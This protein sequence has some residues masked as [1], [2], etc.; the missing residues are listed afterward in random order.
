LAFAQAAMRMGDEAGKAGMRLLEHASEGITRMQ[1]G[2][3]FDPLANVAVDGGFSAPRSAIEHQRSLQCHMCRTP[4]TSTSYSCPACFS[5]I[6]YNCTKCHLAGTLRCPACGDSARNREALQEY[7]NAGEAFSAIGNIGG[8]IRGGI[9]SALEGVGSA[10]VAALNSQV[11]PLSRGVSRKMTGFSDA[12]ESIGSIQV[13]SNDSS[14]VPDGARMQRCRLCN[15]ASAW[16]DH[17]CPRCSTTVCS[18]CICTRLAEYPR[19]PHCGEAE[20]NGRAM[21]FIINANEASEMVSHLWRLGSQMITGEAAPGGRPRATTAFPNDLPPHQRTKQR[22]A[23][24][25]S[26][27]FETSPHASRTMQSG[28]AFDTHDMLVADEFNFQPPREMQTQTH[29]SSPDEVYVTL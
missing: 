29:S 17:V 3:H 6:C 25:P 9:G 5:S 14:I 20:T 22:A 23:T 2:V 15:R 21:R 18:H 1:S 7:I 26:G 24:M 8:A 27:H 16:N 10:T 28:S 4:S 13:V 12:A 11:D 19:C